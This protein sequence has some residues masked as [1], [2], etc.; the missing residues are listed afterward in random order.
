[1]GGIRRGL[2]DKVVVVEC[3][4]GKVEVSWDGVAGVHLSGPVENL[5]SEEVRDEMLDRLGH[6]A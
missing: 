3:D 1:V 2:L 4:G 6:A 5:Y